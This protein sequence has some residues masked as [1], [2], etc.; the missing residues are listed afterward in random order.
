MGTKK[1]Q[2]KKEVINGF[3]S[4]VDEYLGGLS[5]DEK[6]A[7]FFEACNKALE[8]NTDY[9]NDNVKKVFKK[10]KEADNDGKEKIVNAILGVVFYNAPSVINTLNRMK[11]DENGHKFGPWKE[12]RTKKEKYYDRSEFH[13]EQSALYGT[14]GK[15]ETEEVLWRKWCRVCGTWEDSFTKPESL[16]KAERKK[17]KRYLA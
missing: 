8:K 1:E 12:I 17:E 13:T 15:I 9:I 3:Y 5:D 6:R 7:L 14:Y 2:K 4:D 10:F 11:C 16:I